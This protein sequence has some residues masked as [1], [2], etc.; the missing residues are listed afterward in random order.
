MEIRS[1]VMAAAS[2]ARW[3]KMD[4]TA[5]CRGRPAAAGVWWRRPPGA[6]LTLTTCSSVA[7]ART[8]PQ[9][10]PPI[11]A[12]NRAVVLALPVRSASARA[13]RRY[14][15]PSTW[16]R[17]VGRCGPGDATRARNGWFRW[18]TRGNAGVRSSAWLE[19]VC[20]AGRRHGHRSPERGHDVVRA[21]ESTAQVV[22]DVRAR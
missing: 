9:R 16:E 2:E 3:S 21:T 6:P 18:W 17:P 11:I 1:R 10:K 8:L 13:A 15:S 20:A 12:T 4:G 19:A 7:H 5:S 14:P 22:G